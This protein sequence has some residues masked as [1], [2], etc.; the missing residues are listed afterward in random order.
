MDDLHQL[1][2]FRDCLSYVYL[3]HAR[4]DQY[5]QSVAA[6]DQNGMVAVPVAAVTMLMLG[7]GTSVTQAAVKTLAENNCLVVWCGEEN[8]RFWAAGMGGTRSAAPLIHQARLASDEA[9]RLEVVKRMYRKR[10]QEPVSADITVEQLR[11]KEGVRVRAAYAR[12]SE[13]SGVPWTGRYYDRSQWRTA[14][15]INRAISAAN[16]CLYG[17]C[18]AA[19]LSVGY[20]PALGFI[21]T[22]KQ[23]SF[24]YDI[25]DLYKTEISLPVAFQATAE[26]LPDL[27]RQVRLRLRDTF[28]E[29]RLLSRIIPDIREVLADETPL[30]EIAAV[31]E[32]PAQPTPLWSPSSTAAAEGG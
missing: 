25:A 17:I 29:S 14:D 11:G 12:L 32:D 8:V 24:V 3:E 2:K 18:H 10:F 16:S 19:I 26:G 7:P 31:D 15:P 30:E 5:E 23:L 20:S 4:V 27:E 9:L 6:W 13:E 22:G 1:P 21:H 28:R